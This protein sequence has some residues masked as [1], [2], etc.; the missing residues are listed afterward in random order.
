LATTGDIEHID[1]DV[2]M[3][4][5]YV[6]TDGEIALRWPIRYRLEVGLRSE[7]PYL[8]ALWLEHRRP[9][10]LA[11]TVGQL[12]SP[13]SLDRLTSSNAIT[14]L[15]RASPVLAFAPSTKAGVQLSRATDDLSVA[16]AFGFFGDARHPDGAHTTNGAPRLIGRMAWVPDA[17]ADDASSRLLH[18]GI[19]GDYLVY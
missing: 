3:G 14:F 9:S 12:D 2:G 18:L 13:F 19:A 8:S 6:N 1:A 10:G 15:E 4:R 16:W 7:E 5:V 17:F 11:L